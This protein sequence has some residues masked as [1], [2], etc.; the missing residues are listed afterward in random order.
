MGFFIVTVRVCDGDVIAEILDGTEICKVILTRVSL[1]SGAA[2][3]PPAPTVAGGERAAGGG[4]AATD[5]STNGSSF[6][7][8][9]AGSK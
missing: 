1:V 4:A 6:M 8:S 7:S 9:K 3:A 2:T 5:G